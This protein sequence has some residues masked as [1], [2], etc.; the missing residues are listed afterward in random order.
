MHTVCRW[1]GAFQS[2]VAPIV[3]ARCLAFAM[4]RRRRTCRPEMP[5]SRMRNQSL[6]AEAP[7]ERDAGVAQ[8]THL[9]VNGRLEKARI[10]RHHPDKVLLVA[11]V[12][13][14]AVERCAQPFVRVD[15]KA[16]R[17]LDAV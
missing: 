9:A 15:D 4:S 5:C 14:R 10:G 7:A 13:E 17:V 3:S 6:S 1:T 16:V 12:I 8:V 2:G 11:H